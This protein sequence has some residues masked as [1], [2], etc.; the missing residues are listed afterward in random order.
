MQHPGVRR[1][2]PDKNGFAILTGRSCRNAPEDLINLI[3]KIGIA[4][5]KAQGLSHIITT[6]NSFAGSDMKMYILV[7]DDHKSVLGFVKIGPRNLFLWDRIGVQHERK[8]ICLLDF[9]TYPECQRRGYGK[10]MI[11]EMLKDNRMEMSQIPID[12]PS[13][14]CLSFMAKHFGLVDYVPQS[15]NFVA[16]AK[17]FEKLV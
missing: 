10:K 11:D 12:R 14:L 3:N 8:G 7:S 1:L 6:Y 2:N 16:P 17:S 13:S 4:S 5:S 9:F 15:N